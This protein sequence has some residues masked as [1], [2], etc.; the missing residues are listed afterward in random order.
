MIHM[1]MRVRY[2]RPLP[3][4]Y[5]GGACIN[6]LSACT[7]CMWCI[8]ICMSI[9]VY[10]YAGL[11]TSRYIYMLLYAGLYIPCG[12]YKTARQWLCSCAIPWHSCPIHA[13]TGHA[14]GLLQEKAK[15]KAQSSVVAINLHA[16]HITLDLEGPLAPGPL[17]PQQSRGPLA[18]QPVLPVNGRFLGHP[19]GI[20]R[21]RDKGKPAAKRQTSSKRARLTLVSGIPRTFL[22][23]SLATRFQSAIKS[24]P[25]TQTLA[26]S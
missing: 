23:S 14:C 6:Y 19:G 13:S 9:Y 21:N 7:S 5:Y 18:P 24:E 16:R 12:K 20:K 1:L 15:E 22:P 17:A 2:G 10:I 11:Y 26:F 3:I 4:H 8:Y 25:A